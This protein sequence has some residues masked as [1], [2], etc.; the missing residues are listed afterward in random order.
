MSHYDLVL[1]NAVYNS[2][3]QKKPFDNE[4][5]LQRINEPPLVQNSTFFLFYLNDTLSRIKVILAV[6]PA[7]QGNVLVNIKWE[8]LFLWS[9]SAMK[10]YVMNII[11]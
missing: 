4:T 10:M 3:F 5:L 8:Y 2:A 11:A 9:D 1:L 7:L 6:P